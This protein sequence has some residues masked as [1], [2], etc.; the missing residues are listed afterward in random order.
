MAEKVEEHPDPAALEGV[1]QGFGVA[2]KDLGNRTTPLAAPVPPPAPHG[3]LEPLSR[4]HLARRLASSLRRAINPMRTASSRHPIPPLRLSP[5]TQRTAHSACYLARYSGANSVLGEA[6]A[7]IHASAAERGPGRDVGRGSAVLTLISR[8]RG[9]LRLSTQAHADSLCATDS[10][11]TFSAPGSTPE[12][13][14]ALSTPPD[15]ATG[16]AY[17]IPPSGCI[18]RQTVA[19]TGLAKVDG[20]SYCFTSPASV[21]GVSFIKARQKSFNFLNHGMLTNTN[22]TFLRAI[23]ESWPVFEL[24]KDLGNVGGLAKRDSELKASALSILV[25][26]GN[27]REPAIKYMLS[28]TMNQNR[29]LYFWS[30][31]NTAADVISFFLSN[32]ANAL[33]TALALDGKAEAD[34]A[35]ISPDYAGIG[36]NGKWNTSDVMLFMKEISSDGNTN[37]VDVIFPAS[38]ILLYLFPEL[39]QYLLE[40]LFRYQLLMRGRLDETMP[41]VRAIFPSLDVLDAHRILHY[42]KSGNMLI[43]ALAFARQRRQLAAQAIP[44]TTFAGPLEN[45]TNLAIKG[46]VG[47]GAMAQIASRLGDNA[48]ATNYSSIAKDYV[49]KWQVLAQSA[50]GPH[51]TLAYGQ[52][53]TWG[54]A[55]NL[56]GDVYLGLKLFPQ[57]VCDM[58][59]YGIP[60]DARHTLV[61][62]DRRD[63]DGPGLRTRIITGPKDY[64]GNG[65]N[66]VPFSDLYDTVTGVPAGFQAHPV[67][68]GHLALLIV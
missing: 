62:L 18:F 9:P 19:W 22:D 68:G 50:M 10:R 64:V 17:H 11:S 6:P 16:R 44:P 27:I 14:F 43:M 48:T 15:S 1:E 52:S 4:I 28:A 25:S 23:S 56:F 35:K 21:D 42:R 53:A 30:W 13:N 8:A 45:Q 36:A 26:I 65:L 37:P 40:P 66:N 61:A 49:H 51:L 57:S 46:I 34:A 3:V 39:G 38:P 59:Q 63:R 55:Y 32:Y 7:A 58:H 5:Q 67:S 29:S 20:H 24:A 41:V 31:F 12:S 2:W 47:I 54:L 33:T 60:L